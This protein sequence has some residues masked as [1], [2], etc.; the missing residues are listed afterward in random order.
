M[1]QGPLVSII[2]P[3]LNQ[4][5]FIESTIRSVRDQTY[6]H[7]EHIV[8]DGG[9]T[10]LTLD[11]LREAEEAGSLSWTSGADRGMYDAI[12]KGI[13]LAGGEIVGYL[14]SDDVYTPWAL[15][16]VVA[17]FLDDPTAD[18]VYGDGLSIDAV[19][20]RQRLSLMPPFNA[21]AMG[22]VGSLFQPA[23]FIRRRVLDRHSGFEPG[24]R[25]VGDLEFWLRVSRD[26]QFKRVAEVLAV[27]RIHVGALSSA[28]H[29]AMRVEE[30]DVRAR[31]AG[32]RAGTRNVFRLAARARAAFWR[33]ILWLRFLRAARRSSPDEG[34]WD[35]FLTEA[36]VSISP[37]RTALFMVPRV[38]GGFAWDAVRSGRSWFEAGRE[39]Q[40]SGDS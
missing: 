16:T 29:S 24:L 13:S 21:R 27:E 35:R 23:V 40:V 25:F 32:S 10:D 18:V 34:W 33:R 4:D 5:P 20:G 11:I 22:A 9:S 36:E 26:V 8:V 39:D 2:T 28:G 17:T 3:T 37:I 31:Y 38:G 19:N 1:T 15:E 7:F 30:A 14:N 6:R 12:N